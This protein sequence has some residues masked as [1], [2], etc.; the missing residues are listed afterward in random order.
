MPTSKTCDVEVF[1]LDLE[2]ERNNSRMNICQHKFTL[3]L[4]ST[5]GL[6]GC[7]PTTTPMSRDTRL[8][9]TE[10]T[11]LQDPTVYRRLVGQL[12][13]MLNMILDISYSVQQLSQHKSQPPTFTTILPLECLYLKNFPGQGLFFPRH[14]SLQLKAFSNSDRETCPNTRKSITGFY[15]YLGDSLISWKSKK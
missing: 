15:I 2:V 8:G 12:I 5:A 14:P 7:K 11:P 1:L 6:L 3:D 4:L 10:G 13:Y 9:T